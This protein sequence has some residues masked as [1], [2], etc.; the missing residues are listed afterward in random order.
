MIYQPVV[1]GRRDVSGDK[2]FVFEGG[3]SVEL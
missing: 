2:D 1:A 3:S